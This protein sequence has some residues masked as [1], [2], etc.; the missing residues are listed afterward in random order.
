MT[1]ATSLSTSNLAKS[2]FLQPLAISPTSPS[3]TKNLTSKVD[4]SL[5]NP[6]KKNEGLKKIEVKKKVNEMKKSE[7]I[8]SQKNVMTGRLMNLGNPIKKDVGEVSFM[9]L[10]QKEGKK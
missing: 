2:T 3:F 9:K 6:E 4:K 8:Y 10:K 1:E 7:F 5:V